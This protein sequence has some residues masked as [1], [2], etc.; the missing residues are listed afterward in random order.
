MFLAVHGH[1]TSLREAG[2]DAVRAFVAFIPQGAEGE[3]GLPEFALQGRIRDAREHGPLSV[4]QDDRESGPRDLFVQALH[5]RPRHRDE[6]PHALLRFFERLRI[7]DGI[8]PRSRRL[9]PIFPEAAVPGARDMG[10]NAG[11]LKSVLDDVQN[12]RR[13]ARREI[14]VRHSSPLLKP[15]LAQRNL[16]YVAESPQCA[17]PR[18][19]RGS[20]R[21]LFAAIVQSALQHFTAGRGES[22]TCRQDRRCIWS[23]RR[24]ISSTDRR[25][26]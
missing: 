13:M 14:R 1:R 19:P 17:D 26:S 9:D 8:L 10:F 23:A 4:R 5:F 7:Q 12:A 15:E 25:R 11:R 24:P 20:K 2:A 6:F 16:P 18:R 3:A 21:G 22:Q